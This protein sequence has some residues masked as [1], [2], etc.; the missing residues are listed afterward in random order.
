MT[1][2]DTV[3]RTWDD[4]QKRDRARRVADA[5]AAAVPGL[6]RMSMF[7]YGSGTGL[8]GL[9]LRSRVGSL[10]MADSSREM[11]AVAREK[12]AASGATNARAIVLDLTGAAPAAAS[13]DLVCTLLT[14][15]HIPDVPALLRTFHQLLVPGG[16]VCVSDLDEED[17][18]F[19]GAG[20]EGHSGFPRGT[21]TSW[22]EAAGFSDVRI[23][24]VAEIDKETAAGRRR[25]PLFLAIARRP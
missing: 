22:L 21:I 13:Y 19:H 11:I 10:T 1:H 12:I 24:T 16:Y 17:G 6:A 8:L 14:L 15:H 7:E 5:I 2:F 3:A 25:F 4:P 18:S 9:E 23:S 20:F